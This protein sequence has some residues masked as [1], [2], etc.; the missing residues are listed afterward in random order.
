MFLNLENFELLVLRRKRAITREPGMDTATR[1]FQVKPS[2]QTDAP[3]TLHCGSDSVK[4]KFKNLVSANIAAR[5]FV[6]PSRPPQ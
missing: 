2:R 1:P 3:I 4:Y 5:G 6:I